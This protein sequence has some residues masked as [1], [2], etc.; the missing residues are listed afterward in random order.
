[1][2]ANSQQSSP[3]E[4][5]SEQQPTHQDNNQFFSSGSEEPEFLNWNDLIATIDAEIARLCWSTEQAQNYLMETY[6]LKSRQFLSDEQI[7][8]FI[9]R[10]RAMPFSAR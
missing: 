7:L 5:D 3:V 1:M 2:E 10:L 9:R 4:N 8:D 6:G